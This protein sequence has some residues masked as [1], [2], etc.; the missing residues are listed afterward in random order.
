MGE[1]EAEKEDFEIKFLSIV[2]NNTSTSDTTPSYEPTISHPNKN[3]VDFIISLDESD[4]EDYTMIFD[5]NSFSYKIIS[6]N[7]LKMDSENDRVH[8]PS[9]PRPNVDYFDNLDYFDDFKN[10]FPAIVYN[11]G[12]TSKPD[13]IIEPFE[14]PQP[15]HKNETS[16]SMYDEMEQNVLYYNDLLIYQIRTMMIKSIVN[17][18]QGIT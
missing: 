6:V 14:S 2:L 13:P 9:S 1:Y 10:K 17:K 11:D 7:D 12:L 15:D 4:D 8:M 3:K 18:L 5:E 16:L